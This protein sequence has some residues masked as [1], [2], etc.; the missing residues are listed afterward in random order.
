MGKLV[1]ATVDT[2]FSLNLKAISAFGA[3]A[4][5]PVRSMKTLADHLRIILLP[6]NRAPDSLHH[7]ALRSS[8]VVH[9]STQLP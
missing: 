9:S 8:E 6:H 1:V 5:V 2:L 4:G 3:P 7:Q